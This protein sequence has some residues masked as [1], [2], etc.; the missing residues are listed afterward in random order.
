VRQF[1]KQHHLLPESEHPFAPWG[2][3]E[4][5]Q[6]Q[7]WDVV[8][9]A[10]AG[11][12]GTLA[13]PVQTVRPLDLVAGT[14][15]PHYGKR[16]LGEGAWEFAD[17]VDGNEEEDAA[18][19]EPL[20][21]HSEGC[22]LQRA[23]EESAEG[24]LPP[25]EEPDPSGACISRDD[26][27]RG[28]GWAAVAA[29]HGLLTGAA[30]AHAR[31]SAERRAVAVYNSLLR[32]RRG[33]P[34]SEFRAAWDVEQAVRDD[35]AGGGSTADGGSDSA[36]ATYAAA[37]SHWAKA[38][39]LAAGTQAE[40]LRPRQ[41]RMELPAE[42]GPPATTL[43]ARGSM[44]L[45]N[46]HKLQHDLEQ[47][48]YLQG[49]WRPRYRR[50]L[51]DESSPDAVAAAAVVA[52]RQGS[53][54]GSAHGRPVEAPPAQSACHCAADKAGTATGLKR[55]CWTWH[56]ALAWRGIGGAAAAVPMQALRERAAGMRQV[57]REASGGQYTLLSGAAH[58][59]LAGGFNSLL[60]VPPLHV[61]A[62]RP[63]APGAPSSGS[64]G[65]GG[66]GGGSGGGGGG[67]GSGSGSGGGGGG[68]SGG[69]GS[70]SGS[71]SGSSALQ[72][73]V[74]SPAAAW[75]CAERALLQ[76][77]AAAATAKCSTTP[78]RSSPAVEGAAAAAPAQPA[79]RP[80]GVAVVDGALRA[81]AL[82]RLREW[83]HEATVWFDPKVGYVGAYISEGLGSALLLRLVGEMRV[84]MPALLGQLHLE[85]AWGY[86]YGSTSSGGGG[87]SGGGVSGD[88]SGGG[89]VGEGIL[90]HADD[91]AVNVNLWLSP[92]DS[93]RSPR[94]T[95]AEA[96][97]AEALPCQR[98]SPGGAQNSRSRT[99]RGGGLVVYRT[100]APLWGGMGGEGRSGEG[101]AATDGDGDGDG[102][103]PSGAAPPPSPRGGAGTGGRGGGEFGDWNRFD[104]TTDI[105][106]FLGQQQQEQLLRSGGGGSGKA[107][108][109]R[110]VVPYRS[111]R[112]VLFDS[113]LFHR[114]APFV[115][116]RGYTRRRIN[117]TLLF[118]KRRA[119]A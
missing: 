86:K 44:L 74:L 79:L 59:M 9:G 111:N 62:S 68:G 80:G 60:H 110:V 117:L 90:L 56:R 107:G 45:T 16:W 21:L 53:L 105:E 6:R 76:P 28:S 83:C 116:R 109:R 67:G 39:A 8:V 14:G 34:F 48:E 63:I 15:R 58:E 49:L 24:G 29:A 114:T 106:R 30:P 77:A 103:G 54:G 50:I 2:V 95:Q 84:A 18:A 119:E 55:R 71:G 3:C 69:G 87:G 75:A 41:R 13:L 20:G 100:R 5:L 40:A 92:D 113:A 96:A 4:A 85:N 37:R 35:S 78:G 82:S 98:D 43:L 99:E 91:A 26:H 1:C 25:M 61:P 93:N 17:E 102:V 108:Q 115:F 72:L 51:C 97:D 10:A 88:S 11:A 46:A 112:A 118:G 101:S 7:V 70:G 38:M 52:A 89:D 31:P 66:G 36:W 23:V 94:L 81:G 73:Q 65:G 64:G 22:Q 12:S 42:V 104:R 27:R 33:L 32:T 57:L 19:E 47:L